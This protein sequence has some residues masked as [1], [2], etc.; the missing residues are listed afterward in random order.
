MLNTKKLTFQY[1]K[2]NPFFYPDIVCDSQD[3]LLILGNSGVGKSTLLHLLGGLMKP[4]AGEIVINNSSIS[5]L[6]S[7]ELDAFRGKHIGIVFQKHHFLQALTVEENLRLNQ[8]LAGIPINDKRISEVLNRLAIPHKAK[9][10]PWELSQ[11]E[12]QRLSIARAIISKPILLL[13]DEPTSALDDENCFKVL[14]LLKVQVKE[15]NVSLVIVTHD[16]RISSE[17]ENKIVLTH[18]SVSK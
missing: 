11:G 14:E 18:K 4:A 13:A 8:K 12:Q 17:F 6:S 15:E 1:A 3:T 9:K 2:S 7:R 16:S 10:K 5:K